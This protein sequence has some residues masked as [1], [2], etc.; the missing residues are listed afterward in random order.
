MNEPNDW[1]GGM[2]DLI[3]SYNE[4]P[5][6]PRE[7]MWAS[8]DG[9]LRKEAPVATE[10]KEDGILPLRRRRPTWLAP[11]LAAAALM[12]LGV[13]LGRWSATLEESEAGTDPVVA[14]APV[15]REMPFRLAAADYL[16]QTESLLTLFRVDARS[17]EV[18]ADVREWARGLLVQTRIL[19]EVRQAREPGVQPLLEDLEL[20]L[21]QI[22]QLPADEDPRLESEVEWIGEDLETQAILPRVQAVM[23]QGPVFSGT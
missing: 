10:A 19:M 12:V 20:M 16:A 21:I 3:R 2:K 18:D 8:I 17:G 5:E 7:E 22:S 4:P 6:I 13:A 1:S 9:A 11:A 15:Q 23:P 14:T